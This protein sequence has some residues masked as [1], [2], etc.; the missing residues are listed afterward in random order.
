MLRYTGWFSI[1][2]QTLS[3]KQC[4]ELA[5]SSTWDPVYAARLLVN[6][7][8]TTLVYHTAG[9]ADTAQQIVLFRKFV[10]VTSQQHREDV[11][12]YAR[13]VEQ[14]WNCLVA[15]NHSQR[16]TH[17]KYCDPVFPW[18]DEAGHYSVVPT[19]D[20]LE[21]IQA[22][23]ASHRDASQEPNIAT[24][25]PTLTEPPARSSRASC[26]CKNSVHTVCRSQPERSYPSSEVKAT[27][28]AR[29]L[30]ERLFFPS[31]DTLVQALTQ[32]CVV[33]AV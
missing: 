22:A 31:D 8:E 12:D 32:G 18:D 24:D 14:V 16:G 17:P 13:R 30:Q 11:S 33:G 15:A 10:S 29:V 21:E 2:L 3:V 19:D 9:L 23:V 1:I 26:K 4:G 5:L 27:Q 6:L 28:E 25:V 7:I 20:K